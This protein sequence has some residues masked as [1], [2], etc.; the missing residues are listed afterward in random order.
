MAPCV[1]SLLYQ[2]S[3][4]TSGTVLSIVGASS[5]RGDRKGKYSHLDLELLA[6]DWAAADSR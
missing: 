4:L 1:R 6:R 2:N 5:Y 3:L